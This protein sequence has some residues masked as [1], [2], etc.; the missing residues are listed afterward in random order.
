MF[1]EQTLAQLRTSCGESH[2]LGNDL[3]SHADGATNV[4]VADTPKELPTEHV[5]C[6]VSIL[7]FL[8]FVLHQFLLVCLLLSFLL[9]Y[10]YLS[11]LLHRKK[12]IF[13]RKCLFHC[14]LVF[15]RMGEYLYLHLFYSMFLV[16]RSL[17]HEDFGILMAHTMRD[18]ST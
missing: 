5:V 4:S 3:G 2:G 13:S 18:I 15:C 14:F 10:Y 6:D 1:C 8:T 17:L 16:S 7:L 11:I 9:L 12:K